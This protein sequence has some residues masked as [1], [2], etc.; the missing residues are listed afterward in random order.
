MS[1]RI[2]KRG[3]GAGEKGK[4]KCKWGPVGLA[5]VEEVEGGGWGV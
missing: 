1:R 5:K 3:I 4:R 2:G